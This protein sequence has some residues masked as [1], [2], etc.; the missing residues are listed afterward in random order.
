M[1][2]P[3][4]LQQDSTVV[5]IPTQIGDIVIATLYSPLR[6]KELQEKRQDFIQKSP[7]YVIGGDL[8]S[9]SPVWGCKQYNKNGKILENMQEQYQF[10]VAAPNK[11]TYYP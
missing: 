2:T 8:N 7:N 11:P 1:H 6:S 3:M 10:T 5:M 9:K 4:G